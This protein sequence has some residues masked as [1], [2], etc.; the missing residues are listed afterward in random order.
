MVAGALINQ[1]IPPLQLSDTAGIAL[2]WMEEFRCNQLPVVEKEKFIGFISENL[3]K[4]ANTEQQLRDFK[5][6]GA[7][8]L[9][10]TESH[11]YEV[12][13]LSDKHHL[14]LIAVE[15]SAGNYAGVITISDVLPG[16][17]NINTNF[18]HG[19]ILVLSMELISYSLSEISRFVEENNAK[20]ISASVTEDPLDK[21]K[22]RLAIKINQSDLAR[23]IAT[24][25]RFDY[26]IV[27]RYDDTRGSDPDRDRYDLLMR[28]LN[29]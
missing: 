15:N 2:S 16:I 7:D 10:S 5:L 28:Y 11:F 17:L 29:I 9:T 14:P 8:G 3:L 22:I 27:A 21:T 6:F 18:A 26:R 24:L 25:E 12:I 13:K 1:M 23:I 4:Q 19:S 20:I